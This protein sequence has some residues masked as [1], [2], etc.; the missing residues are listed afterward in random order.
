[1]P[2]SLRHVGES[3]HDASS[4]VLKYTTH[5]HAHT[6][7]GTTTSRTWR[8]RVAV[9]GG[10][11]VA[12]RRVAVRGG[13]RVAVRGR[14]RIAVRGRGRVA[15]LRRVARGRVARRR[16]VACRGGGIPGRR[17]VACVTTGVECGARGSR[18]SLHTDVC[19]CSQLAVG[20]NA[21]PHS[22]GS[23]PGGRHGR[24]ARRCQE[25]LAAPPPH[26]PAAYRPRAQLGEPLAAR[27]HAD[28]LA[29]T[30]MR[31]PLPLC[32]PAQT[33]THTATALVTATR[34]YGA[35]AGAP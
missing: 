29:Y 16:G 20:C 27:S 9:R 18:S 24:L 23:A 32:P 22:A 7:T 26:P 5:T 8:G 25:P 12:G 3:S 30:I 17:G 33:R 11:R 15:S 35:P 19:R 34:P 2:K 10:R 28:N 14:G 4:G 1:M 13:G 6:Q 21:A 31:V